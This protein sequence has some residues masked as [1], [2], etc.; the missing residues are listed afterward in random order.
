M[1]ARRTFRSSEHADLIHLVRSIAVRELA[2]RAAE[3][4]ANEDFPRDVFRLLGEVGILGLPYP[5]EFGG[6]GV[7]YE[8]FLQVL[9][10]I[11]AAWASVSASEDFA[12]PEFKEPVFNRS[13]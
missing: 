6:A 13:T 12:G 10:E 9:E 1:P 4:E 7:P 3:A 8:I 5:E 2:P 11:S